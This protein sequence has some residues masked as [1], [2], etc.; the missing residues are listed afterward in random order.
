[1]HA[2]TL[3]FLEVEAT[4]LF[5]MSFSLGSIP[6]GAQRLIPCVPCGILTVD[7]APLSLIHIRASNVRLDQA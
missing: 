3:P 7:P 4:S 5:S 2:H 6:E 1:M